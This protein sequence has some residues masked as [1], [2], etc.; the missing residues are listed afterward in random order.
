[1]PHTKEL[2][3]KIEVIRSQIGTIIKSNKS[4]LQKVYEITKLVVSAVEDVTIDVESAAKLSG[5]EKKDLA[6][7]FIEDLYFEKWASKVV[8]DW[9]ERKILRTVASKAIDRAVA[10]F[11]AAGIFNHSA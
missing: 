4:W 7:N 8:P 6:L 5:P 1:M 10:Y 2:L 11:N 3:D 9:I